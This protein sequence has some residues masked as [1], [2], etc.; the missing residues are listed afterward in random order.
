MIPARDTPSPTGLQAGW[1]GAVVGHAHVRGPADGAE[2][3]KAADS[4]QAEDSAPV[5]RRDTGDAQ[6]GTWCRVASHR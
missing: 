4:L 5:E 3:G 1:I 2:G 6:G